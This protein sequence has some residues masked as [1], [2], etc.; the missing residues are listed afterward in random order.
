MKFSVRMLK[1]ENGR[2]VP[3]PGSKHVQPVYQANIKSGVMDKGSTV[4]SVYYSKVASGVLPSDKL[5]D[6]VDRVAT[7]DE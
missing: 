5:E 6:M 1:E 2:K 7:L 4:S 3:I